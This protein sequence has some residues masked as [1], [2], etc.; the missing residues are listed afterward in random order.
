[1]YIDLCFTSIME[2]FAYFHFIMKYGIIVAGNSS[3]CKTVLT[4]QK[5]PARIMVGDI[6]RNSC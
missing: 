4:Q 5:K 6:P 2:H 3:Y 1:M